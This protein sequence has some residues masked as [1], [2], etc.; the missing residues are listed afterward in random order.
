MA[1]NNPSKLITLFKFL[2]NILIYNGYIFYQHE[3]IYGY[4]K[5]VLMINISFVFLAI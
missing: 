3:V 2:R 4:F 1:K 5:I